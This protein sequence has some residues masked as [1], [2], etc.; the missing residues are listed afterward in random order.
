MSTSRVDQE[1]DL[2]L[3][4][5]LDF[6]GC[7]FNFNYLTSKSENRV[8]EENEVLIKHILEVIEKNKYRRVIFMVGSNRQSKHIDD[9]NAA[10]HTESCFPALKKIC[11]EIK[12]RSKIECEVDA[13]LLAD[14]YGNVTPGEN[15]TK[16]VNEENYKYSDFVWDARKRSIVYAQTHKKALD[17]G[18]IHYHLY[19]DNMDILDDLACFY[20]ND[21]TLLSEKVKVSLYQYN[22]EKLELFQSDFPAEIDGVG[23]TDEF[24]QDNLKKMVECCGLDP[25]DIQQ[26]HIK[27]HSISDLLNGERLQKFKNVR[28]RDPKSVCHELACYID[29][30]KM[31]KQYDEN[32]LQEFCS[33]LT[34]LL[35]NIRKDIKAQYKKGLKMEDVLSS[36]S[37]K[38][39]WDAL[40][41][42][43]TFQQG[44][45]IECGEKYFNVER[46]KELLN[47]TS[48]YGQAT[49]FIARKIKTIS[50]IS[51]SF[52]NKSHYFSDLDKAAYAVAKSLEPLLMHNI[53]E[54]VLL[55]QGDKREQIAVY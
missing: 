20:N 26:S 35:L 9:I 19:D 46:Y 43:I 47:F 12:R 25:N 54:K 37:V 44:N 34:N 7:V 4:V 6:D 50:H 1:E 45:I 13:Y 18:R 38:L 51:H 30:L 16:A 17:L 2:S 5:S 41:L 21:K 52:F 31:L 29:E 11:E 8:I 27:N 15:F 48:T 24:Y 49:S 10:H 53:K 36:D 22:G 40:R 39:A 32:E 23:I 14:T 28:L 55:D 3:V 42:L 33:R